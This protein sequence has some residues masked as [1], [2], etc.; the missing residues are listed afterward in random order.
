[1]Q[2][3]NQYHKTEAMCKIEETCTSKQKQTIHSKPNVPLRQAGRKQR[4]DLEEGRERWDLEAGK[5]GYNCE[6]GRAGWDPSSA[7]ALQ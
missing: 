1:M 5:A 6:G 2:N 3:K 4:S 7:I